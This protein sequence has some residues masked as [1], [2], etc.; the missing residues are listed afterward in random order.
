MTE[1]PGNLGDRQPNQP[2]RL[3][4]IEAILLQTAEQQ[5]VNTNAITQ[6]TAKVDGL[7]DQLQASFADMAAT[8]TQ[9]GEE[10]HEDR[11]VIRE[12]QTEVRGIQTENQRILQY[13]FGQRG[14]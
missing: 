7:A 3:D 10:A 8:I 11:Q 1:T 9:L 13:L 5:Q 4:R 6:L 14:E 2:S 12:M